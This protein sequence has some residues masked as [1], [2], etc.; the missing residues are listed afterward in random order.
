MVW[1]TLRE[2]GD[3]S[4]FE[5]GMKLPIRSITDSRGNRSANFVWGISQT[6]RTSKRLSAPRPPLQ[7]CARRGNRVAQ[8]AINSSYINE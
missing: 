1:V 2:P 3:V 5:L 4:E 6:G 8:N 7:S